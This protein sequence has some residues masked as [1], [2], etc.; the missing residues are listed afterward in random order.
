M[1]LWIVKMGEGPDVRVT[2]RSEK[3]GVETGVE[4]YDMKLMS[5][6]FFFCPDPPTMI[7]SEK[8]AN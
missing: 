3:A 5:K 7:G 8:S 4:G 2:Y 6:L 1:A